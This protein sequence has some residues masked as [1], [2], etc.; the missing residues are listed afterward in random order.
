M[1]LRPID[2]ALPADI[3]RPKKIPKIRS[4][5]PSPVAKS[6]PAAAPEEALPTEPTEQSVEYVSSLDLKPL[7]DPQTKIQV[8]SLFHLF[9]MDLYW[10]CCDFLKV[11]L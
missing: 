3:E 10:K 8:N 2:N 1:A 9:F 5:S 7:A 6:K 11:Y 4:P